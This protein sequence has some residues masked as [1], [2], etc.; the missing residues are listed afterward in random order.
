MSQFLFKKFIE[1]IERQTLCKLI[2]YNATEIP[3]VF[4]N[5]FLRYKDRIYRR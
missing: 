3:E 1:H 5:N 4:S 2:Y